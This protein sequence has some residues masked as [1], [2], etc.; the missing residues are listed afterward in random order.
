MDMAEIRAQFRQVPLDVDAF[1]IP[2]DE[3]LDGEAVPEVMEPRAIAVFWAAQACPPRQA[4]E[5]S[6]DDVCVQPAA[7]LIHK[8]AFYSWKKSVPEFAIAPECFQ[9]G[10]MEG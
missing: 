10:R 5:G 8:E 1:P 7:T 3:R 4:D 9:G 6:L 2:P